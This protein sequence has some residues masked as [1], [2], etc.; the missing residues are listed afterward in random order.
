MALSPEFVDLVEGYADAQ[1]EIDLFVVSLVLIYLQ[2][3]SNDD[4]YD[5]DAV[6]DVVK[7]IVKQVSAGQRQTALLTDAYLSESLGMLTGKKVRPAGLVDLD[8]VRKGVQL[9]TV[10]GRLANNYRYL[11]SI[12]L[13]EAE[14]ASRVSHRAEVMVRTDNVLAARDQE[15]QTMRRNPEVLGWR[16]VIHPELSK[17]GSCGLCIV[18]SDRVYSREHLREIHDLCK[19]TV[20]PIVRVNGTMTDPGKDLNQDDLNAIYAAADGNTRDKLKKVRV[21][22]HNHG[23]LGPVLTYK[24]QHFRSK[25]DVTAAAAAA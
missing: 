5:F 8:N 24:G 20:L 25:S 14:V 7:L 11:R 2:Q 1:D 15:A 16:R 3:M 23:E 18:A 10:Y 17:E 4:W 19:C 22:I 9:E 21:S 12:G 13:A 6:T